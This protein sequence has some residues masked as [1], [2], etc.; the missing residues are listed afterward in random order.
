MTPNSA[1]WSGN[2]SD[3]WWVVFGNGVTETDPVEYSDW[4]TM[5]DAVHEWEQQSHCDSKALT[6][7][8]PTQSL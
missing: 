4:E 2:D 6:Q 3:G 5:Q 1:K 8:L 7:A